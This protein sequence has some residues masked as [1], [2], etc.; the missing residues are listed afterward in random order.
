MNDFDPSEL[1]PQEELRLIDKETNNDG[2]VNVEISHWEY[3]ESKNEHDYVKVTAITPTNDSFKEK[4][5]WPKAGP[6]LTEYKFYK[7]VRDCGLSMVEVDRLSGQTVRAERKDGWSLKP[8]WNDTN[9]HDK[10]SS[11]NI[12]DIAQKTFS[13][14]I[15]LGWHVMLLFLTITVIW[16]VII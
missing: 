10:I 4:M 13:V 14:A 9:W 7:L 2:T 6:E 16:M 1:S 15:I 5:K 3:E 12:S 8:E 11:I